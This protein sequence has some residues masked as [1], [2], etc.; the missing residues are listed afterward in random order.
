MQPTIKS[1]EV[2]LGLASPR[3][4]VLVASVLAA[5]GGGGDLPAP[6][7]AGASGGDTASA[8]APLVRPPDSGGT[9]RIRHA[10][11]AAAAPC[12]DAVES[13]VDGRSDGWV[14][15]DAATAAGLTVVD[16][17]DAW[18]PRPFAAGPDGV[19]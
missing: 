7:A 5:C 14:C 16:L 3:S 17:S 11:T 8:R 9:P 4:L 13:F 19:A 6:G 2:A 15:A 12:L 10:A 18:A 1:T